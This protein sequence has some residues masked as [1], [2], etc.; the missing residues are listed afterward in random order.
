MTDSLS[1]S[2]ETAAASAFDV[3]VAGGG[4]AGLLSAHKICTASPE[5]RVVLLEKEPRVGGRMVTGGQA[6]EYGYGFHSVTPRLYEFWNQALKSDPEADDLPSLINSRLTRA[7]IL[8]GNKLTEFDTADLCNEKGARAL[9][10]LAASRQWADVAALMKS[11]NSFDET[12]A[13]VWKAPRKSPATLVLETYSQG[14]GITN[15]WETSPGGI[16]ERASSWTSHMYAGDWQKAF[17]ALVKPLIERGQLSLQTNAR[18]IDADYSK[19]QK[20][21]TADTA[22]GSFSAPSL[23]VAQPPWTASQWL[24]KAFWPSS[25]ATIVSKTKPVSAVVL[26]C[27][28]EAGDVTDLPQLVFIPA[29]SVQAT[30]SSKEIVF[31]ATIDY[32]MS[33]VAPDVVKA[34]KRLKRA[35]RKLSAALPEIKTGMEHVALMPVSWAQSPTLSERKHLDKLKMNAVQEHHLS[36]CGDAY[37][38]SLDG[39]TN[40]IESVISASE[41]ILS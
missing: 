10:G 3:I 20:R 12:F 14:F 17:D 41:A 30:I 9:G 29:E 19:E 11:E 18:I 16:A 28:I 27:P 4:I 33:V 32:E 7:S 6:S 36:F 24:P 34:V 38:Q 35:H 40:L 8:A 22:Q 1:S 37:G 39:D 15:I 13:E 23:V 26:S 5:L 25:L 31:Q 2:P 21:W